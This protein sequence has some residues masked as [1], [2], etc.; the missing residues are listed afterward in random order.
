VIKNSKI[1]KNVA[2]GMINFALFAGAMVATATAATTTAPIPVPRAPLASF[3]EGIDP[4]EVKCLA[5]N[6]YFEAR[7]QNIDGQRAVARVTLNRVDS[8][9]YPDTIC[10]VV[11][12]KRQFSWTHDGLSD[13]PGGNTLEN[14]AWEDA[15]SVAY[16]SLFNHYALANDISNGAVMYHADYVK[17]YWANKYSPVARIDNHVFYK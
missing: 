5:L 7:N 17:P 1:C 15:Q 9:R 11:W 16:M 2:S 13:K 8:A 4:A 12:E 6:I 10:G 14:A 3:L